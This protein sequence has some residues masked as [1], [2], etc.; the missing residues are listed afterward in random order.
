MEEL[1]GS[2]AGRSAPCTDSEL[3]LSA[4]FASYRTELHGTM[5]TLLTVVTPARTKRAL[6][7]EL[8]G[9]RRTAGH[10]RMMV[11][12]RVPQSSHQVSRKR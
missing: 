6:R 12:S 7:V 8:A 3:A 9:S 2:L 1:A 10:A 11:L 5:R 4:Y